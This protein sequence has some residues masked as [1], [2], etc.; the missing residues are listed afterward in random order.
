MRSPVEVKGIGFGI[1]RSCY[2]FPAE[3]PLSPWSSF[4]HAALMAVQAFSNLIA[5]GELIGVAVLVIIGV[6][7]IALAPKLGLECCPHSPIKGR[8]RNS[9]APKQQTIRH[10]DFHPFPYEPEGREFESLR[11]H[12]AFFSMLFRGV[13]VQVGTEPSLDFVHAHSLAFAVVGDLITVD[14]A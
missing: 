13:V 7:L 11:A 4:A 10:L 14:L 8:F 2:F 5:R 9:P 12:Q 6:L 1:C 3:S